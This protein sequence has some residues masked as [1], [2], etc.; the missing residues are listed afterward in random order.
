LLY[1]FA[2]C[3]HQCSQIIHEK[4]HQCTDSHSASSQL[5]LRSG[6][7]LIIITEEIKRTHQMPW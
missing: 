2:P 7:I 6:W 5:P 1:I 3:P 4:Y